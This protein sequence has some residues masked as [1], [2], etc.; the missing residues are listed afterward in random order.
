VAHA[1][2]VL[3]ATPG[4]TI[5]LDLV[6]HELRELFSTATLSASPSL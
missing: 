1:L 2:L 5:D 6:A 4:H 3:A